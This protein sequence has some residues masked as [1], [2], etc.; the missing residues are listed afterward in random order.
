MSAALDHQGPV[1]TTAPTLDD[2]PPPPEGRTGWPWT[3][4]SEPLPPTRPDG[5]PWPLVTV[6][7]P[8]YNQA[9]FLEETVRSVL[10]QGY[11]RLEYMIVD[12]GSTDGS[13]EVMQKYAPW[14]AYGVSE[15]DDGQSD[16]INKGFARATGDV[17]AWLN[18]DDV[19]FADT[20]GEAV[21]EMD[22]QDVDIVIGGMEKFMV[23]GDDYVAL[24]HTSGADG[25]PIHAYPIFRD[26]AK[27]QAF[28]F[29]Q[30][31]MFWRSWVWERTE[32][33]NRDFHWVMD[34]EWCTRAV[35]VGARVG[36]CRSLFA[37]FRLHGASKTELFNHKQHREQSDFYRSLMGN[38][39]YRRFPLW[40][41]SQK[42]LATALAL[43]GRLVAEEGARV[44]GGLLKARS[45]FI[46]MLLKPF[47]P[48]PGLGEG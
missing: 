3:E 35:E 41:S 44:R 36:T 19:Y 15:K 48:T 24:S 18:S 16:A 7:T 17:Q 31:P 45:R 10:L 34:I 4:G 43:E 22:R 5:R 38:P 29:M 32:G 14:L 42:S 30:P 12:G 11:P 1:L 40:L 39:S 8:S 13:V 27:N 46:R 21:A 37:R 20:L 6:V 2:L 33:L 9:H 25:V 47:P 28:H 26:E 23:R